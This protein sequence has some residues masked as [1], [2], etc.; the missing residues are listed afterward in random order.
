MN[1]WD[2]SGSRAKPVEPTPMCVN[3][4]YDPGRMTQ[5]EQTGTGE[6][7]ESVDR[8]DRDVLRLADESPDPPT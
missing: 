5:H 3:M 1:N 4:T 6:S 7:T 8:L 2:D